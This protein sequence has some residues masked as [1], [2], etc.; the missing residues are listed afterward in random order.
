MP[1]I[2]GRRRLQRCRCAFPGSFSLVVVFGAFGLLVSAAFGV[3]LWCHCVSFVCLDRGRGVLLGMKCGL[4]FDVDGGDWRVG[5]S[6][7]NEMQ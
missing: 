1:N 7:R 4:G 6:G 3:V 5:A 2:N